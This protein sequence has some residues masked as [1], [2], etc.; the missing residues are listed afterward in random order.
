MFDVHKHLT[1]SVC[2]NNLSHTYMA[3]QFR[4]RNKQGE[5]IDLGLKGSTYNWLK[6]LRRWIRWL[7]KRHF[8]LFAVLQLFAKLKK[9]HLSHWRSHFWVI[10][11]VFQA[12]NTVFLGF[13]SNHF[14]SHLKITI[15]LAPTFLCRTNNG[16][17]LCSIH[18][19]VITKTNFQHSI[20]LSE[21]TSKV[22]MFMLFASLPS[23]LPI[24]T[25]TTL[26]LR[27]VEEGATVPVSVAPSRPVR[28]VQIPRTMVM[29]SLK[30]KQSFQNDILFARQTSSR[31]HNLPANCPPRLK[32][33]RRRSNINIYQRTI[34]TN[35]NVQSRLRPTNGWH[36]NTQPEWNSS[37]Y[38]SNK[39]MTQLHSMQIIFFSLLLCKLCKQTRSTRNVHF[40]SSIRNNAI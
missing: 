6:C 38:S 4:L 27:L 34:R 1:Y 21:K 16:F 25:L 32:R 13:F 12:K 26:N 8:T 33:D 19:S 2:H 5:D 22:F 10:K 17:H 31:H 14:K 7:S 39:K 24:F 35:W 40:K 18:V 15:F 23:Q 9:S 36:P 11:I 28:S 37:H 20:K 30:S 29:A 3:I